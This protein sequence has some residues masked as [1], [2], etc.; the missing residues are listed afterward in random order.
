MRVGFSTAGSPLV[1]GESDA[2]W[3]QS[4]D[5]CRLG[6]GSA[7][8]LNSAGPQCRFCTAWKPR[9]QCSSTT[10]ATTALGRLE[11]LGWC[12]NLHVTR[13]GAVD[14]QSKPCCVSQLPSGSCVEEREITSCLCLTGH[15]CGTEPGSEESSCEHSALDS[16]KASV[17]VGR[18]KG[19][20]PQSAP[21]QLSCAT[22]R[23]ASSQM[24]SVPA[25]RRSFRSACIL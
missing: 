19:P 4:A 3:L 10:R 13:L 8:L 11:L 5:I 20:L 9:P 17:S 23:S 22:L 1:L 2:P 16:R 18:N 12:R 21:P 24:A 14:A 7:I 25:S 6:R 15:G